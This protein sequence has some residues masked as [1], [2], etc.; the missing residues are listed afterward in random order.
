MINSHQ[1]QTLL[2]L[3]NIEKSYGSHRILNKV[4]FSLYPGEI[5]AL[6][7]D[8]GAGK[9]TLVQIIS[10]YIQADKGNIYWQEEPLC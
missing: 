8:N 7:G 6:I 4:S 2:R 9:S 10:G 5:T 3:E 1:T